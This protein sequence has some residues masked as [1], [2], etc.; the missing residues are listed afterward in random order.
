M[1]PRQVAGAPVGR[2]PARAPLLVLLAALGGVACVTPGAAGRAGRG[3]AAL[4]ADAPLTAGTALRGGSGAQAA[5]RSAWEHRVRGDAA[6]DA[7]NAEGARAEWTAA[8]DG[9]LAAERASAGPERLALRYQAARLHGLAQA[10]DRAADEAEKVARDPAADE[11][12]RAMGWHLAAHALVNVAT[13]ETRAGKLPAIKL[14]YADQRTQ[15]LQPTPPPGTWS[16][17]VAAVDAYLPV[18]DADPDAQLPAEGRLLLS[19]ARLA[20]G[21]AKVSFAFDDLADARA[22][23]E[24]VLTRWPGEAD[25]LAE[26]APLLLQTY[27]LQNDRPGY[28]AA[29]ARLRQLVDAQVEKADPKGKEA[30]GRVR[31][32]L[33]RGESGVAFS[34]AQRLLEA[35]KPAEAAQAFEA[36]ASDPAGVDAAGALH[37]AAIAWDRAEQPAR[38]AAA[39]ERL[40]KERPDAKVAAADALVLAAY[41]AR[42]GDHAAAAR[43]YGDFLERWPEHKD[44]CIA[45]QNV[46][47]EL[48]AAKRGGDAAERY[49]AF[50][51]EQ[52]CARLDAGV[53]QSALARAR[54]LFD[55]AG[56]PVR[57]K[58]AVA[59]AEALRAKADPKRSATTKE[60]AP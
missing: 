21:A 7:A 16:R 10:Y 11:R 52:A 31:D 24:A 6:R 40:L 57:A 56:K 36:I 9:L 25:A 35:G 45:L 38:A 41:Q 59:A 17:F 1:S 30:F 47:S 49:L 27:L 3:E 23:L 48:D 20:V 22:R 8:A 5:Y 42:R 54:V 44:R 50:G 58:E 51:R 46:A 26:A 37:N 13:A 53:A 2:G 29:L 32:D 19:P 33:A 15:P 43:L 34:A 12:S 28:R 39:R 14:L 60:T 55:A 4:P 18:S